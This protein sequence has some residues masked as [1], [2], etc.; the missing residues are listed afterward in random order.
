VRTGRGCQVVCS[1]AVRPANVLKATAHV[2]LVVGGLLLAFVAYQLWGTAIY[3][4]H[5]QAHL[6]QELKGELGTAPARLPTSAPPPARPATTSSTLPVDTSHVA[7]TMADPA[8]NAPVGLLSIP[9]IGMNGDVIVEGTGEGQLQQGPGHYQGTPL[10]GEAGNA[11]IAGHRT[12]YGAPFYDLDEL[13]PGDYVYVQTVQ[14]VFAYQVVSSAVVPPS[15]TQVLAATTTPQL[16]LTTCNPRYSASSRLVVTASLRSAITPASFPD[17]PNPQPSR[18]AGPTSLAAGN[19]QVSTRGEALR[20]VL[21]GAL[22][23][24]VTLLARFGW[25]RLHTGWRWAVLVGGV[26]LALGLLLVCFQHVSLAL[27]ETF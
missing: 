8:L 14:G 10:P 1:D 27:P 11:A 2:F 16:T 24:A 6:R 18:R 21:W 7:P 9:R 23:A 22:A 17:R 20:G 12:T 5:A 19:G 15:D 4:S 25:R 26:P 13:Q 3:E